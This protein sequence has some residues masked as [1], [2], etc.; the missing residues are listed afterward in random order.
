MLFGVGWLLVTPLQCSDYTLVH[1]A[2][3][4]SLKSPGYQIQLHSKWTVGPRQPARRHQKSPMGQDSRHQFPC[5]CSSR[6]LLP[7]LK[8]NK[9][10]NISGVWL[11][12]CHPLAP[13]RCFVKQEYFRVPPLPP[14]VRNGK[15]VL[16]RGLWEGF[17][18][19][20]ITT[21]STNCPHTAVTIAVLIITGKWGS[22][23]LAMGSR[24]PG[25]QHSSPPSSKGFPEENSTGRSLAQHFPGCLSPAPSASSSSSTHPHCPIKEQPRSPPRW[26]LRSYLRAA[27]KGRELERSRHLLSCLSRIEP[28]GWC[29]RESDCPYTPAWSFHPGKKN[30]SLWRGKASKGSDFLNMCQTTIS[31]NALYRRL[32]FILNWF[33]DYKISHTCTVSLHEGTWLLSASSHLIWPRNSFVG[34]QLYS[35]NILQNTLWGKLPLDK[36]NFFFPATF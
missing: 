31:R 12:Q 22:N 4:D 9:L 27:S 29:A 3:H 26:Q 1:M 14:I 18:L 16:L 34:M 17:P 13:S 7:Y 6:P 5:C 8:T 36:G 32:S 24:P 25:A 15:Q 35:T 20:A 10:T 33:L 23:H 19:V 11:K 30:P 28:R 21:G 2:F